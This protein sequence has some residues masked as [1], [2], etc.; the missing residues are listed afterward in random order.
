MKRSEINQAILAAKELLEDLRWSLPAW[1][2]WDAKAYA[3][4]S[5]LGDWLQAHQM[6][7]DVTDFGS[8]D[9]ARRGLTLF[10]LRNGIQSDTASLPYAEKLLFVGEE[11]ETPFHT[12][13]NKMEDIINRG[14]GDL[15]IEF[16]QPA[17]VNEP[18]VLR[19]DGIVH[20]LEHDEPLCLKPG[21]S[22]TIPRGLYHRFYARSGGGTVLGGEVSQVNDDGADNYFLDPLGRFSDIVEDATPIHPLWNEVGSIS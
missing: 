6:G 14:G 19:S 16:R 15:M 13:K 4:N 17:G 5:D 22:V 8:G 1:A 21:S 10:C 2:D 20:R 3:S 7:W 9:F 12:H 18:I 11:Q